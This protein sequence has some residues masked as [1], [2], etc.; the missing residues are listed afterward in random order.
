[1]S[2]APRH[3]NQAERAACLAAFGQTDLSASLYQAALER[4]L[5]LPMTPSF[6]SALRGPR[7][8]IA[9][10]ALKDRASGIT[11]GHKV[12][13]HARHF[14]E[15]DTLPMPLVV[16]ELVHVVQFLRDG[17]PRFLARYLRDYARNLIQGMSDYDAYLN[18][19]YEIEARQ[20][21]AYVSG[22]WI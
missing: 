4:C 16:H 7:A 21:E 5:I 9:A 18:I 11:L 13:I 20:I 8:A 6:V 19:P 1:M 15:D 2:P 14:G 22:S 17:T 10:I 12:Y 3:L